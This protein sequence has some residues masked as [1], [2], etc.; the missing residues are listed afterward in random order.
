MTKSWLYKFKKTWQQKT[1]HWQQKTG[2]NRMR[3]DESIQVSKK[4]TS[5]SIR[6]L[7]LGSPL[8][9]G[10]GDISLVC[11]KSPNIL[12]SE[13]VL[14]AETAEDTLEYT[15]VDEN[16]TVH[17]EPIKDL[18]QD[19]HLGIQAT[20][21][22]NSK[23][24]TSMRPSTGRPASR[25]SV[26]RQD[27][28]LA[29]YD[30]HENWPKTTN[31]TANIFSE[32]HSVMID[33][34]KDGETDTSITM[35]EHHSQERIK[36]QVDVH[37]LDQDADLHEQ[38]HKD[39]ALC[40]QLLRS[41][42]TNIRQ[43]S[44]IQEAVARSVEIPIINL[45]ELILTEQNSGTAVLTITTNNGVVIDEDPYIQMRDKEDKMMES[46]DATLPTATICGPNFKSGDNEIDEEAANDPLDEDDDEVTTADASATK[47]GIGR[48]WSKGVIVNC[49][50]AKH[51]TFSDCSRESFE[52]P[53]STTVSQKKITYIVPVRWTKSVEIM[54]KEYDKFYNAGG[55]NDG[56]RISKEQMKQN[57]LR[58]VD[59]QKRPHITD[60]HP[61]IR[62]LLW[63]QEDIHS[64][65]SADD[66]ILM[67]IE[68]GTQRSLHQ[69]NDPVNI[70]HLVKTKLRQTLEPDDEN[71]IEVVE[72]E[73]EEEPPDIHTTK[74]EVKKMQ[75]DTLSSTTTVFSAH[76]PQETTLYTVHEDDY[77]E[78]V[79]IEDTYK[80]DR[81]ART[82]Q[83][84]LKIEDT[85]EEDVLT[86]TFVKKD[87][88]LM[89]DNA[90]IEDRDAKTSQG[91][92][93]HE[94]D[95]KENVFV[96]DY[97]QYMMYTQQGTAHRE[98]R[99]AKTFQGNIVIEDTYKKDVLAMNFVEKE[100]LQMTDNAYQED[101]LTVSP[102]EKMVL[103]NAYKK[104]VQS[105]MDKTT[106]QEDVDDEHY[107]M[108]D[109]N[110]IDNGQEDIQKNNL[111]YKRGTEEDAKRL[112]VSAIASRRGEKGA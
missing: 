104:Y 100:V 48:H 85:Y 56:H 53:M 101:M 67:M 71:M 7:Q 97:K 102:Q 65:E 45:D 74:K 96:K 50:Y 30:Q 73:P 16:E 4:K 51:G 75:S 12:D 15:H 81:D 111:M 106:I 57:L 5:L 36:K 64:D 44:T 26:Q 2:Q 35:I 94:A 103:V 42:M 58:I 55:S 66:M 22:L 72:D 92:L 110:L 69:L 34:E 52:L 31:S 63:G 29:K 68:T 17:A 6:N 99:D 60:G 46:A 95:S 40:H 91:N 59:Q 11:R 14:T 82:F 49:G 87:V 90:D 54:Q 41:S 37:R 38:I 86:F 61:F 62:E 1:K 9:T 20:K 77:K 76:E 84:N 19:E 39:D 89:I 78:N 70:P 21:T 83:G 107:N 93:I 105:A 112:A 47:P 109:K 8:P 79:F 27:Q 18:I 23:M 33:T 88:Q 98:D 43:S 25:S 24:R 28:K 10:G 80:E 13:E 32:V 108:N 3:T